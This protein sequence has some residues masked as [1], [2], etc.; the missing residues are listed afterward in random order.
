[1]SKNRQNIIL[2]GIFFL[3]LLRFSG[4][5]AFGQ[6]GN[7]S[8]NDTDK[9]SS[10]VITN[11]LGA[12]STMRFTAPTPVVSITSNQSWSGKV[13]MDANGIFSTPDSTTL[14][15]NGVISGAGSLTKNGNGNLILTADKASNTN[16]GQTIINAGKIIANSKDGILSADSA[17]IVGVGGTLDI[18]DSSQT[19]ASLSGGGTV[20]IGT[21]GTLT[22]GGDDSD[23]LF[24]GTV[25]G[26]GTFNKV[27][28]GTM[29]FSSDSPLFTGTANVNGGMLLVGGNLSDVSVNVADGAVLG[30]SGG[31]VGDTIIES[32]GTL[33]PGTRSG[34]ALDQI[35]TLNVDGNLTMDAGSTLSIR[36]NDAGESD[37]IIVSGTFDNGNGANT[38]LEIDARAGAYDIPLTY[39][40]F[41]TDDGS[42]GPIL[43][44]HGK[45][46]I[47]QKFLTVTAND[48]P[49]TE[50][51]VE[52]DYGF[53]LDPAIT[54]NQS[55]VGNALEN[56]INEN[57]SDKMWES[58][59][60]L[61]QLV[62]S[63]PAQARA[64]YDRLS[65]TGRANSMMLGQWQA[66]RY[67][68]S[69]L[70]LTPCGTSEGN[71][72]WLEFIHQT[73]DMDADFNSSA[74][75]ISR[76]G[77][78]IG[79]EERVD[80][81]VT[82]GMLFGYS[83]PYLYADGEEFEV[84]DLHFGFYGGTRVKDVL[85][86]K[87]YAGYG[88]QSYDS[89]RFIA[90]PDENLDMQISRID[91]DYGGDSMSMALEFAIPLEVG[92]FSFRP[93]F[94][95][96]S[97]LTWQYG[98]AE[99]GDS[100]FELVYDRAF[101]DRTFCR[102]GFTSQLGSVEHCT[103][104]ALMSRFYYGRQIIGDSCPISSARFAGSP[105]TRI[106]TYGVDLG[107]DYLSGG[108]G[109]RWTLSGSRSFYGD[110]DLTVFDK[111]VGHYF[112]LG[113]IQKW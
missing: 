52:R 36:I 40:D 10:Y 26:S 95:I 1:M 81:D 69:H 41:V 99:T 19:V 47:R 46:D 61:S 21:T 9:G 110:Y 105:G 107:K 57:T 38:N 91:G 62:D 51:T 20:A 22:A 83:M 72:V 43:F 44:D 73:T 6:S 3:S 56:A 87:I 88:H 12:N 113:Y 80:D 49:G 17:V 109:F 2:L 7:V 28:S 25:T 82:F 5:L 60:N 33:A 39:S 98:C 104:F 27:G 93:V 68:L 64:V 29:T 65:G 24:Y 55:Q 15:I 111:S 30:G 97:D 8:I 54:H 78:L 32:G 94:A 48:N 16:T 31:T 92:L 42:G 112:S 86:T 53:F 76:T 66:S 50:L 102:I 70:D 13:I 59:T 71:G 85:E 18:T 106:E 35:A 11:D 89:R 67:G 37:E 103:P 45:I 108:V 14:T 75:G 58:L 101:W 79:S 84:N 90:L 34:E 4:E 100:G 63:S 77:I 23:T 96:D 74:Y